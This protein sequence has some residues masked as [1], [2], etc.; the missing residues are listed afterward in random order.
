MKNLLI[1]TTALV[2]TTGVA[3]AD[4][5]FS[6]GGRFGVIHTGTIAGSAATA[7]VP[8]ATS[9]ANIAEVTRINGSALGSFA[10]VA[11]ATA[12]SSALALVGL[13]GV[14]S[15]VTAVSA[16]ATT[17]VN[18]TGLTLI[19]ETKA[20]T[21]VSTAAILATA[22]RDG[23]S[24]T[25]AVT[26]RDTAVTEAALADKNLADASA[27]LTAISGADAVAAGAATESKSDL[28]NRF[29][30]NIDASTETDSGVEFFSRV[31]IRGSNTGEGATSSSAISA[32]RVGMKVGGLTV[33]V[34]NIT[35][36]IESMPGLYDG[37]VGLTGLGDGQVVGNGFDS[38][39]SA[40]GGSNGVEVLYSIN[41]MAFHMSHSS[42]AAGDRTALNVSYAF[43]DWNVALGH[44]AADLAAEEQTI[45]TVGGSLG[46]IDLG[47]AYADR[48]DS[49]GNALRV[50]TGFEVAAG[51]KVTLYVMDADKVGS[52]TAYG[53]GF[54]H[55]LG[56]ATLAGGIVEDSAGVSKADLGVRFNF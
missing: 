8:G 22:I 51:T 5:T 29:T 19:A 2:A 49:L 36:A 11:G 14:K 34:G 6:G 1:A 45:V 28:H 4:I 50:S 20:A 46:S 44:Q 48:D 53:L 35:G 31:R 10:T 30:L 25:T 26:N 9:A 15:S 42:L 18:A 27:V 54:T 12:N 33:A 37:G 52:D 43:G 21:V 17:S 3:A 13:I 38:F 39:S 16:S 41:G 56:G 24:T 32:P 55:S 47:M 7:I 40:G 23:T